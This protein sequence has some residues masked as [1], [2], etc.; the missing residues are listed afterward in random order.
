MRPTSAPSTT[1]RRPPPSRP[2]LR[3]EANSISARRPLGVLHRQRRAPGRRSSPGHASIGELLPCPAT[4]PI[5]RTKAASVH[6]ATA[7]LSYSPDPCRPPPQAG[8]EK[9]GTDGSM[10]V[11]LEAAARGDG[12][13]SCS[14]YHSD[15]DDDGNCRYCY[16]LLLPRIIL[17]RSCNP[18]EAS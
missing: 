12:L 1:G 17:K 9:L 5:R 2:S 15:D 16:G 6:P 10:V 3:P 4:P 11:Q 13:L 14:T 7:P 18:T 8:E